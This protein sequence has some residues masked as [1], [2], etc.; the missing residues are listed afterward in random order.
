MRVVYEALGIST[1]GQ[2]TCVHSF[3]FK[4]QQNRG[5]HSLPREKHPTE[6]QGAVTQCLLANP[7]PTHTDRVPA[8]APVISQGGGGPVSPL[9]PC[10]VP[11]NASTILGRPSVFAEWP[12][13]GAITP[14]Q[15]LAFSVLSWLK[16]SDGKKEALLYPSGG[17][18]S[19]SSKASKCT[20]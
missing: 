6:G 9:P 5:A 2:P 17:H 1:G 13:A 14:L 18:F 3:S 8:Q 16:G 15:S 20:Q 12:R 7:G 19:G 11:R 10:K 4:A